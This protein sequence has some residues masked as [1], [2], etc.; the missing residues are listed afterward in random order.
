MGGQIY[1][2]AGFNILID[3]GF[4]FFGKHACYATFWER[5][6]LKGSKMKNKYFGLSTSF[7]ALM[8]V[9]VSSQVVAQDDDSSYALEE[10]IV[11]ATLRS[12]SVQDVPLTVTVL[13]GEQIEKADIHDGYGIAINTPG[14][15][16]AEFAPG[17][18]QFSMRG[19]GSGDD[20]AGLDNSVALFLDGVYIGRGAGV[21]FDM[22]DLERVEVL[23]GPQGTL[24]GR[25][26]IGGAISVV[27]KKP[28]DEV[29]AK[30]AG[31][32][33][34]E[35][36]L[37]VQAMVSGPINDTLAGKVVVSH[38][39]HDGF[40]HNTLLDLD[41]ND[42][43]QT[44]VRGQLRFQNDT[45]DWLL[46]GDYMEDHRVDGGRFPMVNGNF[47]YV[48]TSVALG[49]GTKQTNSSPI[50]G[51]SDRKGGGISLQGDIE[52]DKGTLTTITAFRSIETDWEMPSVGTPLGGGYNLDAGVYGADVVDAIQEKVETISEE[53][54]WTSN[55][56]GKFN[57]IGGLFL[58]QE[59]TDR[60][61]Q[62]RIDYNSEATGQIIVGEEYSRTENKTESIAVYGQA[63]WAISDQLELLVGGRFSYD[64]KTYSA[65]AVNCGLSEEVKAAA[66]FPNFAGCSVPNKSLSIVSEVF[67][68]DAGDTWKDFSPMASLQYTVNDDIMVFG[69]ISTGFKSGGFAGSQGVEAAA[70][71]SVNPEDVTN[72]EVGFKG[73]LLDGTMRLNATAFYMKYIDLQVVRFGP[74]PSSPFGTFMTTNVGSADIKGAEIELTWQLSERF[75]LGLNYAYLDTKAKDIVINGIDASGV[76]LG[77]APRNSYNIVADYTMPL[78]DGNGEINLNAQFSH[79]DKQR[80]SYV[81]DNPMISERNL[82]SGRITWT[83]DD[84]KFKLALWGKNLFDKGY[85]A[86]AYIIGPGSIGVWGPPR[87]FGLT[88]TV[89]F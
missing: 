31:T 9:G 4:S 85:T 26:T 7:A 73:D 22:F 3:C 28:S 24:F 18:A 59:K 60:P 70:T 45:S 2:E 84:A 49:A 43:D 82:T 27:S 72:Y 61:E 8:A 78:S 76:D 39:Q 71:D 48:G 37:R 25:N 51:F 63:Q 52:F 79:V 75:N 89:S 5:W 62:W 38:R 57:F 69:T 13:G 36:I 66:G 74:V 10:I 12:A 6:Y 19:V 35:G 34:N 46:S 42:E 80:T 88:G 15:A 81:S 44:A 86:H 87:T 58:F 11:T 55:L 77:R 32:V 16:F 50:E 47:D 30:V 40:V 67:K 21:N 1:K 53:L 17:Q 56:E 14:L 64:K 33:G 65:T 23:K 68:V 54:R 29:I 20:G 83:S 41:S